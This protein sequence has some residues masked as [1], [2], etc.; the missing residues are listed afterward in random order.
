MHG[1]SSARAGDGSWLKEDLYTN[2]KIFVQR[3]VTLPLQQPSMAFSCVVLPAELISRELDAAESTV[4]GFEHLNHLSIM[5]CKLHDNHKFQYETTSIGTCGWKRLS[6]SSLKPG[7]SA[8]FEWTSTLICFSLQEIKVPSR[9]WAVNTLN[10]YQVYQ[11]PRMTNECN[12]LFLIF[13]TKIIWEYQSRHTRA[14]FLWNSLDMISSPELC[15][16]V[17]T[18]IFCCNQGRTM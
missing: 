4:A 8:D 6:I 13:I 14:T 11:L 18:M 9:V 15:S 10:F 12:T 3:P 16:N 17:A 2:L 7:G 5:Y 1:R